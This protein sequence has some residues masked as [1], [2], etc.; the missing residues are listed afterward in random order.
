MSDGVAGADVVEDATDELEDGMPLELELGAT[1]DDE[2]AALEETVE[3]EA[4]SEE[5][6]VAAPHPMS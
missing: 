1:E 5:L 4:G 6:D 3:D 2:E